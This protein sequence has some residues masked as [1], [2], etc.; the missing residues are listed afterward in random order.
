MKT[1][2]FRSFI[3][4]FF[5]AFLAV[6]MTYSIILFGDIRVVDGDLFIRHSLGSM[7][8]GW[9]FSVTPLFFEIS[10]L[11]LLQQTL[12]HFGTVF[13]L[14]FVLSFGIGWVPLDFTSALI[15]ILL[16]LTIYLLIWTGFYIYFKAESKKLNEDLKHLP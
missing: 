3:G 10:R 2:L 12:L 4:I 5:G 13:L 15:A 8:C 1:F 7:F 9:F 6:L 16:F 14:Y 11:T